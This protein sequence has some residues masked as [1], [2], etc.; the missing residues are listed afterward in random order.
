MNAS[1]LEY[2]NSDQTTSTIGFIR[3]QNEVE[4]DI[5]RFLRSSPSGILVGSPELH[6]MPYQ[7]NGNEEPLSYGFPEMPT[8]FLG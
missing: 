8:D 2:H 3:E 6:N 5:S 1:A 4:F 7:E